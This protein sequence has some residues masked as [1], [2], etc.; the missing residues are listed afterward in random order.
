MFTA[1]ARNK[2]PKGK[3]QKG[4]VEQRAT[5]TCI[6]LTAAILALASTE[7]VWAETWYEQQTLNPETMKR[8]NVGWNSCCLGSEVVKTQFRVDK[9]THGDEWYYLKDGKWKRVPDDTIHWG[10]HAPNGQATLFIYFMT[11]DETCFYPP[12]E[13]I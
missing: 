4:P 9:T 12:Q 8:L 7:P 2:V 1:E 11:G 10:Q 3:M 13:G 5:L 6:G